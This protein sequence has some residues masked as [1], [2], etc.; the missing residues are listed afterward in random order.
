MYVKRVYAPSD[1]ATYSELIV[2]LLQ[3]MNLQVSQVIMIQFLHEGMP[4]LY[5]PNRLDI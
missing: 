3:E 2:Q 5:L 1:M 4:N